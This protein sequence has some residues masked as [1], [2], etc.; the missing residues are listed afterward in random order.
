[1]NVALKYRDRV[2]TAVM[3]PRINWRQPSNQRRAQTDHEPALE[4]V[5]GFAERKNGNGR[6][7]KQLR[8]GV[9][10]KVGD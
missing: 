6:S 3:L 8:G 4:I 10:T 1:M 9:N 5:G 7:G 2:D